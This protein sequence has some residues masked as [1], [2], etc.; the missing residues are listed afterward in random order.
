MAQLP[1][2]T[3]WP[4]GEQARPVQEWARHED[5][6]RLLIDLATNHPQLEGYPWQPAGELVK[7]EPGVPFVGITYPH[8]PNCEEIGLADRRF[9]VVRGDRRTAEVRVIAELSPEI[10]FLFLPDDAQRAIVNVIGE[11]VGFLLIG[12]RAV[13][14]K[15]VDKCNLI[16]RLA[17]EIG[18]L[19]SADPRNARGPG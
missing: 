7:Q 9:F 15:L 4:F 14:A 1:T 12:P 6:H 16:A 17:V 10:E 19:V 5:L 2:V 8:L 18:S 3:F 13:I 11:P